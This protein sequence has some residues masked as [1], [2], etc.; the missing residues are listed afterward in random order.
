MG[1][2]LERGAEW[3]RKH[4]VPDR[5]PKAPSEYSHTI[6]SNTRSRTLKKNK[7]RHKAFLAERKAEA[8]RVQEWKKEQKRKAIEASRKKR[9]S[10]GDGFS[11]AESEKK[12]LV[13]S[14]T[15]EEEEV[16][17]KMREEKV[18]IAS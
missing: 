8:E 7:E 6:Y 18:R 3:R 1:S 9:K 4:N 11:V 15:E 17:M 12:K 5:A 10:V 2:E 13:G 16:V 14:L